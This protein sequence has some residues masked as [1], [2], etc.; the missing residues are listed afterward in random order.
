M[1]GFQISLSSEQF[2]RYR[3]QLSMPGMT[4]AKQLRLLAASCVLLAGDAPIETTLKHLVQAGVGKIAVVGDALCLRKLPAIL[5]E[6]S[7]PDV[8]VDPISVERNE[9]DESVFN[10]AELVVEGTLDWQFKLRISD[11][12]M[13]MR[14]PLIHSGSSGLRFQLFTMVPGKSACLRCALPLAGIDDFPLTPVSRDTFS[15]VA[16][17]LG[18]L[19]A[20]ESI[21]LLAELGATQGNELWKIDGLSGEIEIVRGLDPKRDCPDCGY[22]GL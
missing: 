16:A 8:K 1:R 20:L 11:L 7:N 22:A 12:C 13:R 5:A 9:L 3:Q 4:G 21:K 10:D 15:P 17:C 2:E 19:M 14:V 18:S 6:C